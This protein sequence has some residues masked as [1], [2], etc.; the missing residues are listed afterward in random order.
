MG[1]GLRLKEILRKRGL[2]IKQLSEMT[3]I[4]INTLYSITKRDS[5]NIDPVLLNRITAILHISNDEFW[6]IPPLPPREMLLYDDDPE[7]LM[8]MDTIHQEYSAFREYLKDMGYR[9]VIENGPNSAPEWAMYDNRNN[10][11]YYVPAQTLQKLMDNINSYTKF[12]VSS[13]VSELTEIP[14]YKKEP[15]QD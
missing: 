6:G 2:T 13:I 1:A 15:P 11:K 14:K 4:S 9:T 3:N 5:V 10:K 8:E 7:S 12:Q